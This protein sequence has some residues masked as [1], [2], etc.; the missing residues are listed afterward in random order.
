MTNVPTIPDPILEEEAL[1]EVG[2]IFGSPEEELD[3]EEE[4]AYWPT[5]PE[6]YPQ[7]F[8]KLR[9]RFN[10]EEDLRSNL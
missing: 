4:A 8:V 10:K 2:G 9:K 1:E 3:D 5:P 6:V 7:D